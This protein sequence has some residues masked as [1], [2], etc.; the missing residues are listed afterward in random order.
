MGDPRHITFPLE[1]LR[2]APFRRFFDLENSF[3]LLKKLF[4][5]LPSPTEKYKPAPIKLL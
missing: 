4:F 3:S 2:L 5:I 1:T